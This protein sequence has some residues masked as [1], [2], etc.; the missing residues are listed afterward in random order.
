M[1][2]EDIWKAY[3][4]ASR[5]NIE[6]KS[7]LTCGAYISKEER[8]CLREIVKGVTRQNF[9]PWAEVKFKL[10]TSANAPKG[11]FDLFSKETTSTPRTGD[12]VVKP[13]WELRFAGDFGVMLQ[14]LSLIH[15]CRCRRIERCRSRWS[16]YH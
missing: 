9:V 16:P 10:L 5:K 12:K 3:L 6:A 14:D 7:E 2:D 4:K 1:L 8:N 13:G 15:I 11:F